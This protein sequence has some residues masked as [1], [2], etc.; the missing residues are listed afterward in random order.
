MAGGK[1][2]TGATEMKAIRETHLNDE[3]LHGPGRCVKDLP[4]SA[5]SSARPRSLDWSGISTGVD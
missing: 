3:T 5:M 2:Q 4:L 1:Q